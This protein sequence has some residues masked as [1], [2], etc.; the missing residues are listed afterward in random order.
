MYA[1]YLRI[2]GLAL[3]VAV[4]GWLGYGLAD[5]RCAKQRAADAAAAIQTQNAAIDAARE[6]AAAES[7]RRQAQAIRDAGRKAAAREAKLRGQ[8]DAAENARPGCDW[9]DARIRLLNAAAAAANGIDPDPAASGL[10]GTL[11]AD[12]AP[13]EQHRAGRGYV[14]LRTD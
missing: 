2:A 1:V 3:V 8:I 11:P 10:R 7:E 9:P 14:D 12:T 4:A 6:R 5:G 13:D